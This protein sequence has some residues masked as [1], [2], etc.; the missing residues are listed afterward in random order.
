MNQQTS[1]G[2]FNALTQGVTNMVSGAGTLVKKGT[3]TVGLTTPAM[4]GGRR[5]RRSSYRNRNGNGPGIATGLTTLAG[6][7]ILPGLGIPMLSRSNRNKRRSNHNKRRSNR[8][9]RRTNRNKNRK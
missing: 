5:R 4:G 6:A 2:M 8:N 1:P 3:N 7:T 9:K